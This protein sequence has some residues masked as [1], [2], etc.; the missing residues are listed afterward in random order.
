MHGGRFN[1]PN[2]FP[3]LYLCTTPGCAAAEFM[4]FATD[5]PIGPMGFLPRALFRYAV[6]FSTILDLTDSSTLDHLGVQ[7]DRLVQDDRTLTN[8]VGELAHQFL[9]Q[10][11]LNGSATGVDRVLS[12]FTDNLRGGQ[13]LPELDTTWAVMDDIPIF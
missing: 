9:Y 10:G 8:Q 4:R 7:S 3:V 6:N 11:I 13:L 12:V 2:S 5:H 1:P